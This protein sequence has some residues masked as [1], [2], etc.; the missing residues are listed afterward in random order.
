MIKFVYFDVAQTLLHKPD[1][2]T[3]IEGVLR[4]RGYDIPLSLIRARHRT[5]SELMQF[6]DRTDRDFYE[7]FNAQFL[8]A[9]GL[10]PEKDLAEEI[11]EACTYKPWVPFEDTAFIDGLK[12]RVGILSNWDSTLSS[13]LT[14]HFT[15]AFDIMLVSRDIGFQKPDP[16]LF[17]MAVER[18][19]LRAEDIL[20]VGDS[21]RLDY[22]PAD[23]VGMRSI[24][25]DREDDYPYFNGRRIRSLHELPRFM[26]V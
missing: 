12:G 25:I 22:M 26:E 2:W 8:L 14:Q 5:V 18:T 3:G 7:R 20:F 9:L 13:R 21:I 15:R 4:D 11:F 19:G 6:P 23:A 1:V 24:L 17:R 16:H 10:A